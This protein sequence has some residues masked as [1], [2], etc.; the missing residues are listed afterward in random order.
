[1]SPLESEDLK[2]YYGS[3]GEFMT[4]RK[5]LKPG[6]SC[7]VKLLDL[8]RNYKTKYPIKDKE[9]AY[10]LTFD[11]DGKKYLMDI[12]GKDVLKQL[13]DALYPKGEAGGILPCFATLARRTERKTYQSEL[14]VERGD[15]L[16]PQADGEVPY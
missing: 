11:K 13:T 7:Q 9:Y 12:N 8:N 5:L 3:S 1:M 14:T 10:R 2:E 6:D 15:A 16:T 4:V